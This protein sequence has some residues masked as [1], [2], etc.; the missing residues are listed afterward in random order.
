MEINFIF[1]SQNTYYNDFLKEFGNNL[2]RCKNNLTITE[3]FLIYS[4]GDLRVLVDDNA[5]VYIT[6]E[7]EET[8]D[9]NELIFEAMKEYKILYSLENR[10]SKNG[11]VKIFL[12]KNNHNVIL[13]QFELPFIK[14]I[15]KNEITLTTSF[16][17]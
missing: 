11:E 12:P 3:D 1:N 16:A 5:T 7:K 15:L 14:S 8:K 13:D 17:N 6:I 9:L 10:F 2:I 4:E